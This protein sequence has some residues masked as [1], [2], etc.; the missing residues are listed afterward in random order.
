MRLVSTQ[1]VMNSGTSTSKPVIK[2]FFIINIKCVAIF[3]TYK[4]MLGMPDMR[5]LFLIGG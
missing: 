1:R 2:Y 3:C 5:L 4:N